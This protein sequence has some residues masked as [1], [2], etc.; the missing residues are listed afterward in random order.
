VGWS[1]ARVRRFSSV[2]RWLGNYPEGTQEDYAWHLSRFLGWLSG[3]EEF[4]DVTPD[5]LVQMQ[6]VARQDRQDPD[7]EYRMVDL[8][9]EFVKNST[10]KG[11][12]SRAQAFSIIRGFFEANRA[13]LPE[14]R[15]IR[16]MGEPAHTSQMTDGDLRNIV[17]AAKVRDRSWLLV[18]ILGF[19]GWK[20]L[21]YMNLYCG[22]QV[23]KQLKRDLIRVDFPMGRKRNPLPFYTL[24]GGSAR[25]SLKQFIDEVRGPIREGEAIWYSKQGNPMR[26]KTF[27]ADFRYLTMRVGLIPP[28]MKVG[29]GNEYAYGGHETRDIVRSLWHRSKADRDCALFF[30]GHKVDPNKYDK[31]YK[32]DFGWVEDEY[33][34]ALPHIDIVNPGAPREVERQQS[35]RIEAIQRQVNEAMKLIEELRGRGN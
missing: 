10:L 2:G 17:M 33:R 22:R 29:E 16:L 31:I 5:L 7:A 27:A 26:T 19:M 28:T 32:L 30:M 35:E 1:G 20:E 8:L 24:F 11:R 6:K 23:M 25:E 21:E 15:S 12:S 13:P 9:A 14:D 3:R 34:L 4:G 18:K